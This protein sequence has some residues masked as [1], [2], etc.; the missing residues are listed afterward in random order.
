MKVVVVVV[1]VVVIVV[2]VRGHETKATRRGVEIKNV[3]SRHGK[4]AL[5]GLTSNPTLLRS[6]KTRYRCDDTMQH[7]TMILLTSCYICNKS[8][9]ERERSRRSKE[10]MKHDTVPS[11]S[12]R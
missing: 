11:G 4:E 3:K 1:V 5:Y 12:P 8:E 6:V 7:E 2:V 9:R 10:H